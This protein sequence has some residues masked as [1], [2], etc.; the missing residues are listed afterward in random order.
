MKIKT[1]IN[2][3][4]QKIEKHIEQKALD[5]II[6]IFEKNILNSIEQFKIY[7]EPVVGQH[8]SAGLDTR[9]IL[10]ILLANNIKPICFTYNRLKKGLS[11]IDISTKICNKYYLQHSIQK[12]T[13]QHEQFYDHYNYPM[14]DLVFSG[15]LMSE[16]FCFFQYPKH[17]GFIDTVY[18]KH[19][20]A[21]YNLNKKIRLPVVDADLLK[22]LN[23][24]VSWKTRCNKTIQ[25]MIIEQFYPELLEFEYL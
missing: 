20:P 25:K 13:D 1:R 14:V 22:L 4:E 23:K 24:N 10:S 9:A 6:D 19:I 18:Y 5:E 2:P 11:D 8:L 17:V 12:V 16:Y 15:L 7:A 3:F 21:I